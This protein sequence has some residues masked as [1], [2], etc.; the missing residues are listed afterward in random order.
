MATKKVT[1]ARCS[2]S[3]AA[4]FTSPCTA[5]TDGSAAW[6]STLTPSLAMRVT[7]SMY[8]ATRSVGILVRSDLHE[9]YIFTG[10]SKHCEVSRSKI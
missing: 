1:Q 6:K 7:S 5:S 3:V 10:E 8:L 4:V 2:V 9:E